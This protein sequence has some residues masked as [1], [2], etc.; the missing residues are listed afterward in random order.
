MTNEN[1]FSVKKVDELMPHLSQVFKQELQKEYNSF[2]ESEE[3]AKLKQEFEKTEEF[4]ERSVAI[5]SD[6]E[7]LSEIIDDNINTIRKTKSLSVI[8]YYLINDYLK[9]H[10][11]FNR[12]SYLEYGAHTI[13]NKLTEADYKAEDLKDKIISIYREIQNENLEESKVSYAIRKLN[14]GTYMMS[15]QEKE[16]RALLETTS[17]CSLSEIEEKVRKHFDFNKEI[18]VSGESWDQPMAKCENRW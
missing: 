18:R 17:V 12:W 11:K 4:V 9:M 10:D 16:L 6:V 1:L 13:S 14:L 7:I 2:I 15:S 8:N 3:V 5:E